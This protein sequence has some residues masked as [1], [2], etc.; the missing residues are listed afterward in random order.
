MAYEEMDKSQFSRWF[1]HKVKSGENLGSISRKY[2][3]SIKAIQSSNGMKNTRLRAGQTLLIPLPSVSKKNS[4]KVLQ[5][6][7]GEKYGKIRR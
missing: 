2:G 5:N 4:S 3:L 7:K 1:H 6:L